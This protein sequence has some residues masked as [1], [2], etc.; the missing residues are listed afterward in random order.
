MSGVP[1]TTLSKRI[2]KKGWDVDKALLTG[3]TN[4]DIYNHVSPASVYA[5]QNPGYTAPTIPYAT[6]YIDILG[7][8]YTPEEWEAHQ[9]VFFD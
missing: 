3:A 7:R 2:N 1:R 5:M 9:A 6:Y 4:P 8:Y